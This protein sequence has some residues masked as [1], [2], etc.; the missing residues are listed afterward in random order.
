MRATTTSLEGPRV[1]VPPKLVDSALKRDGIREQQYTALH[2]VG[3]CAAA[4]LLLHCGTLRRQETRRDFNSLRQSKN[5]RQFDAANLQ[6][7]TWFGRN[8][9]AA[10]ASSHRVLAPSL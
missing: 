9:N 3:N 4:Q 2:S 6:R 1:N 7:F 10:V 8:D 5:I